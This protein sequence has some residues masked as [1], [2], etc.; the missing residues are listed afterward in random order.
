MFQQNAFMGNKQELLHVL[1][2]DFPQLHIYRQFGEEKL[3]S[4]SVQNQAAVES[5][6]GQN[7]SR[8]SFLLA[9]MAALCRASPQLSGTLLRCRNCWS[10]YFT[11]QVLKSAFLLLPYSCRGREGWQGGRKSR[12]VGT[13]LHLGRCSAQHCQAEVSRKVWIGNLHHRYHMLHED[14]CLGLV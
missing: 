13:E 3:G 4:S 7:P 2:A 9:G 12:S 8:L 10:P 1:W 5:G 11:A 6:E 14:V